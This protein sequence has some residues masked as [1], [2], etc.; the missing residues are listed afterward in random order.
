MQYLN[1][2]EP[3]QRKGFVGKVL[4]IARFYCSPFMQIHKVAGLFPDVAFKP[5]HSSFAPLYTCMQ[6]KEKK[7]WS[8]MC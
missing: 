1:K 2:A 7:L 6:S 5:P 3:L 8:T 4:N